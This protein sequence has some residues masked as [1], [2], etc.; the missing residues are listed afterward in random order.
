MTG[1]S[2]LCGC[3]G[4]TKGGSF[5]P[6]HDAKYKSQLIKEAMAGNEEAEQTLA[7]RDWAKF[8]DKAREIAARPPSEKRKPK[9]PKIKAAAM[10][11][12]LKAGAKVLKWT[13]QYRSG[14]I[15][16][17]KL[18]PENALPIALLDWPELRLPEPGTSQHEP[19]SPAEKEAIEL[20]LASSGT[21]VL[22]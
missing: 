22:D 12:L 6:G 14:T 3:G 1:P 19:F 2:C 21:N 15:N 4:T 20:A 17:V 18:T 8:L 16:S 7:D 11:H 10:L 5:L 9:A 13:D